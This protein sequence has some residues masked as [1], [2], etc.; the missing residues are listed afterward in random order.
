MSPPMYLQMDITSDE[1]GRRIFGHWFAR[2]QHSF[3]TNSTITIVYADSRMASLRFH[4]ILDG[5]PRLA[6]GKFVEPPTKILSLI[7]LQGKL[8]DI[9]LDMR[10]AVNK[11]TESSRVELGAEWK[12]EEVG[13]RELVACNVLLFAQ[14][15]LINIELGAESVGVLFNLRFVGC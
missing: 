6:A 15:L 13:K 10:P 9:L 8:R 4:T 11:V 12:V 5:L 14:D 7:L 2:T 1:H 3:A